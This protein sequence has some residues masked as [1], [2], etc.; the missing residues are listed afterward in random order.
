MATKNEARKVQTR[1]CPVCNTVHDLPLC[2]RRSEENSRPTSPLHQFRVFVAQRLQKPPFN[3]GG[4]A[5]YQLA[6][7][8]GDLVQE[9]WEAG[10]LVDDTAAAVHRLYMDRPVKKVEPLTRAKLEAAGC[11]FHTVK[12]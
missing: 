10:Y 7:K 9:S 4:A 5:G 3:W 8:Y 1:V 2:D 12:S 11:V 6:R